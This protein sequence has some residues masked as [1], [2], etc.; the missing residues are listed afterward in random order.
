MDTFLNNLLCKFRKTHSNPHA[1]FNLLQW[2][3]N[4]LSKAYD[5]LPHDLIAAK[6][7]VY[8]NLAEVY[9]WA[10]WPRVNIGWKYAHYVVCGMKL[11]EVSFKGLCYGLSY[12]MSLLMMFLCLLRKVKFAILLTI[13]LENL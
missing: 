3:Q 7:K 1:F 4:K 6:F 5:C 13:I 11:R 2:W 8:E 12:L 10:T 9:Y